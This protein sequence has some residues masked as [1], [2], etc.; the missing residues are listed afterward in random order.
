MHELIK[1]WAFHHSVAI[2]LPANLFLRCRC[3]KQIDRKKLGNGYSS[4]QK[5]KQIRAS[6]QLEIELG[7]NYILMLSNG[8]P[9]L[10]APWQ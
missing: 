5:E 8:R 2:D 3:E 9:H 6:S 7:T 4:S 10:C 1:P